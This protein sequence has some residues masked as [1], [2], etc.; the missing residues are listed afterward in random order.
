MAGRTAAMDA[1]DILDL[2]HA[3]SDHGVLAFRRAVC[4]GQVGCRG[5]GTHDDGT[6]LRIIGVS[7]IFNS[8]PATYAVILRIADRWKRGRKEERG[9]AVNESLPN[10]Q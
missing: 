2:L 4:A 6:A 8:C 7:D 10:V 3:R 1:Q 9:V 5:S